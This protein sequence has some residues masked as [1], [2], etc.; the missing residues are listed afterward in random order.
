MTPVHRS[1]RAYEHDDGGGTEL[2]GPKIPEN[3]IMMS[4]GSSAREAI[5][6][7]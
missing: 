7:M 3:D 4:R 2:K 1:Y 6:M 5:S